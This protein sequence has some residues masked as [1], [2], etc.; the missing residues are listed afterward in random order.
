MKKQIMYLI[1]LFLALGGGSM[2]QAQTLRGVV[3]DYRSGETLPGASIVVE[4]TTQGTVTQADGTYT[5][6]LSAGI[7]QINVRFVGYNTESFEVTLAQG[8]TV[9]RN[10]D[11]IP[12][13]FTFDEFIVVGYG[14]RQKS[15]VTGAIASVDAA[16]IA[17]AAPLRI[18]QVLQGRAAGVQVTSNS[19]QPGDDL[20]VRV[21]GVGTINNAN[22]LFVVDG[23][24]VGGIDFLNPHDIASIEVLKDASATAI[25][26]SRGANG[27]ILITTKTGKKDQF[28]IQYNA[29]AGT[30][31]P[32]KKVSLLDAREYAMIWNEA[33]ANDLRNVPF[34]SEMMAGM[35]AGT[36]WQEAIFHDNAP[37]QEHNISLSGGGERTLFHTSFSYLNQEGIVAKGKSNYERYTF[38][39]NTTTDFGRLRVGNQL[40][41]TNKTSRG[42]GTNEIFGGVLTLAQNMDPI[43]PVTNGDGKFAKSPFMSQE[44]VNPAAA[45]DVINSMWRENK[46]VGN[47]WG[48]LEL[49][50]GLKLRSSFSTDLAIGMNDFYRPIYDLGGNVSNQITIANKAFNQWFTWQT[51]HYLAYN[52]RI[53]DHS[54]NLLGGFSALEDRF[55]G[56][57]GS[58]QGLKFPT[59]NY[60]VIDAAT[61][62]ES[63]RTGGG[64]YEHAL[65]SYFGRMNYNF[66]EKYLLEGVFRVD[67]SSNFGPNNRWGYFP[68][69]SAGWVISREP[70]LIDN[71]LISFAKLRAGWGQNGNESIGLYQYSSRVSSIATYIFGTEPYL[72]DGRSPLDVSNTDIRWETSEQI[73]VA[74]DLGFFSNRLT[75][76]LDYY[77]KTTKDWLVQ[78]PI[79]SYVGLAPAFINGGD[80]ENRGIEAE[81]SYK[82]KI[83]D[84]NY[85]IGFSGAYNKNK[86]TRIANEEGIIYGAGAGTGMS[87]INVA[88]VGQP[89][90]Y[91]WGYKTAGVF[92]SIAEVQAHVNADGQ[93]LQPNAQPGDI[94]FLDL[95]KDGRI[96]DNDRTMIGNPYPD[97]TMGLNLNLDY[98][99]FDFSMFWYTAL[100]QDIFKVTRRYD[101]PN[102][103]WHSSVLERWT[104]E[105]TSNWHPRVTVDDPNQNYSRVSDFMLESG[106]YLRLKDIQLGY[107]LPSSVSGRIGMKDLRFYLAAQN[108]ITL[109]NYS[110]HDPEVGGASPINYG[111]DRGIYPQPRSFR[112]GVNANF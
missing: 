32:W 26:G 81:L 4:G 12:D 90:G 18:E 5:L 46:L 83:S 3:K 107:T 37:I 84:L 76:S 110:G 45:I 91:F 54:I 100:G 68:S 62:V 88:Q 72:A 93:M 57:F 103:N 9:V 51:E 111:I 87:N 33:Y 35:G 82:N 97:F 2:I 61:M 63:D 104:G 15:V 7:H 64:A 65:V 56:L 38:R 52:T 16:D 106:D 99:N 17:Q 79:P 6:S 96:D 105:G 21:R 27:V 77:I 98:K 66:R 92:Q 23:L 29:F 40:A 19:G 31:S 53:N 94:R 10:I 69:V 34:S 75:L 11:L 71:P 50:E 42:I 41:F 78:A 86:V 13:I 47:I 8:E 20:T 101:L 74:A 44:V 30:Q 95:S 85:K 49:F 58:R 36:D 59:W 24:P 1:F 89:I 22:P 67:G 102:M 55:E 108:L 28:Q 73:N 60:T 14:V 80:V 70:F 43:T 48:E 109:T 39:I 25:Y 112:L